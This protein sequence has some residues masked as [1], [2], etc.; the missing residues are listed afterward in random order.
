MACRLAENEP[1]LQLRE[2]LG[3]PKQC[4]SLREDC[5]HGLTRLEK[6]QVLAAPGAVIGYC[7]ALF[8]RVGDPREHTS[9]F[10][11]L[12]QSIGAPWPK[13]HELFWGYRGA[14]QPQAYLNGALGPLA[15]TGR[16]PIVITGLD[17][18]K[19]SVELN[20]LLQTQ[21]GVMQN[22]PVLVRIVLGSQ[23]SFV[24]TA[25]LIRSLLADC[26]RDRRMP[27]WWPLLQSTMP[28]EQW[29]WLKVE[30]ADE[31]KYLNVA[32]NPFTTDDVFDFVSDRIT[33]AQ[34]VVGHAEGI[35]DDGVITMAP[36]M[37][38]AGAA[39]GASYRLRDYIARLATLEVVPTLIVLGPSLPEWTDEMNTAR[40]AKLLPHV[41]S[42]CRSLWSDLPP[43]QISM[44]LKMP[45]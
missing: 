9:R 7:Q 38:I 18:A 11:S 3:L 45:A 34:I 33:V 32:V 22:E 36:G 23:E 20:N 42:A 12:L 28:I 14:D 13:S 30:L 39:D 44:I 10:T 25:R 15:G 35:S 4:H 5:V 27:I 21:P 1:L 31:W 19:D 37:K 6:H 29:N 24:A 40:L 43:D 16:V 41:D 8:N 17:P 26:R 2:D